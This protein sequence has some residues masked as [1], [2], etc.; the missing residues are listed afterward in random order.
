MDQ[1]NG[2]NRFGYW[3]NMTCDSVKLATEGVLYHQDISKEQD[4]HFFRKT[5]CRVTPIVYE[6][7]IVEKGMTAYRYT[8]P[9]DTFNRP[10]N[11]SPDCY[12]L[13]GSKP[14]PDGLSDVS[15]CF[16]G[17]P[18]VASFPHFLAADP[19]VRNSVVGM[20]P[21]EEKHSGHVIVEPNT[22]LPLES[23]AGIQCNL[24][25]RDVNGYIRVSHFSNKYLPVFWMQLHQVGIPQYLATLMYIIAVIL[26]NIQGFISSFMVILGTSLLAIGFY[27]FQQ[28]AAKVVYSYISL[29][30]MPSSI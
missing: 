19:V 23:K 3:E 8:L 26:P 14:H 22:G 25:V 24:A 1:Y 10:K 18:M 15:P 20:Q 11:G 27:R 21:D 30:T 6:K 5:L 16:H 13:P 7:E 2:R 12:T 29:D 28:K 9:L 4:L 17:I